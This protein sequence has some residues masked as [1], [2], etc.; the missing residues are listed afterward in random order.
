MYK[1]PPAKPQQIKTAPTPRKNSAQ[2]LM[3][4]LAQNTVSLQSKIVDL[5]K[6]NNEMLK[7]QNSL[8]KSQEALTNEIK[9][10]VGL[11][12]E[13]GEQMVAETEEEKLR[14]LLGKISELLEQNKNI[15]RGLI[16]IQKYIKSSTMTGEQPQQRPYNPEE[17]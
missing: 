16:L 10:M 2:E 11:F 14:P 7:T 12:K 9:S 13:A 17:F 6:T 4:S 15:I 8:L 5:A 3:K 1:L